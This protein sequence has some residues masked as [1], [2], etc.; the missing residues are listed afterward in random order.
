[1]DA[2]ILA[3]GLGTRL[4]AC[5]EKGVP[6]PMASVAGRPFLDYLLERLRQS[7]I[8]TRFVLCVRHEWECIYRHVGTDFSGVPVLYHVED[9]PYGTGGALRSAFFVAKRGA[10]CLAVNGDCLCDPDLREFREA[11]LRSGCEA[12][13]ALAR[14]QDAGRYGAVLPDAEG[15]RVASFA[16]KGAE[17]QAW[18]NAGL[19][20]LPQDFFRRHAVTLPPAF[21]VERDLFEPMASRIS[22]FPYFM[23]GRFID[24]GV[25]EDYELAQ[26]LVPEMAS[27]R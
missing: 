1:M 23:Q 8:V 9:K 17:G 14:T 18:I 11:F 6:K 22:L 20:L 10:L 2:F 21:S 12:G 4:Q 16:A 25:P 27:G 3:G 24:V 5:L 19:Y 15:R 7:G 26:T 13:I